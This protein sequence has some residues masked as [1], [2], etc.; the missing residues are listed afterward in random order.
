[1]ARGRHSLD[2]YIEKA[3]LPAIGDLM[4]NFLGRML[5]RTLRPDDVVHP[6]VQPIL[7]GEVT[8]GEGYSIIP[9]GD[10]KSRKPKR[11]NESTESPATE[12][13]AREFG[14]RLAPKAS[15]ESAV[16]DRPMNS[17]MIVEDQIITT[18]DS[19]PEAEET[20]GDRH[21]SSRE[22]AALEVSGTTGEP[23]DIDHAI[24][25]QDGQGAFSEVIE[26]PTARRQS[27]K[28][29]IGGL[30]SSSR[31][32][33]GWESTAIQRKPA[34]DARFSSHVNAQGKVLTE[35]GASNVGGPPDKRRGRRTG[36]SVAKPRSERLPK[37]SLA[38]AELKGTDKEDLLVPF[39]SDRFLHP[40]A[41]DSPR[42]SGLSMEKGTSLGK[43]DSSAAPAVK[44][45][46]GRI[47]V[48][49][50]TQAAPLPQRRTAP[51]QP[52]L[53]LADYLKRRDEGIQ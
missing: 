29:S 50:V 24:L 33:P 12:A 32:G 4:S 36:S 30:K 49:A 15:D 6:V 31:I 41:P 35:G 40:E 44:V 22:K 47:E 11:K 39:D 38:V 23:E 21:P 16:G 2:E 48:R 34:P 46:I 19:S 25:K 51:A 45:T 53:S 18:R 20:S 43:V 42:Q 7:A 13:V 9:F 3:I 10:D 28:H 14:P 1:M 26:A 52:K 5:D 8:A 17:R 27:V 37:S